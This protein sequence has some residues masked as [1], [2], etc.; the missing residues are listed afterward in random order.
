MIQPWLGILPFEWISGI[1]HNSF[2]SDR[3]AIRRRTRLPFCGRC[4][5]NGESKKVSPEVH[6]ENLPSSK[7]GPSPITACKLATPIACGLN[8]VVSQ[9]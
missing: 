3:V 1:I 8:G 4:G 7:W 9:Q 5:D 2:R 6:S